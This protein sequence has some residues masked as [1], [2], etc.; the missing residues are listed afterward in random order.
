MFQGASAFVQGPFQRLHVAKS[1]EFIPIAHLGSFL[2]KKIYF[3]LVIIIHGYFIDI[4]IALF[5][6]SSLNISHS[7]FVSGL[8]HVILFYLLGMLFFLLG[9]LLTFINSFNLN[10][11]SSER[12]SLN[13]Q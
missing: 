3:S 2:L 12:S 4:P 11:V 8:L 9:S 10:V 7:F 5:F 6:S 13:P 1:T